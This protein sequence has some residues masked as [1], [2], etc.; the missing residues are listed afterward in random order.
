MLGLLPRL[1]K[2]GG[3]LYFWLKGGLIRD[4]YLLF[5]CAGTRR[6]MQEDR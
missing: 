6:I 1:D 4:R 3:V 5:H 2:L